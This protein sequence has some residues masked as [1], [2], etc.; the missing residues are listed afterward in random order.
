M[1]L[2]VQGAYNLLSGIGLSR[3]IT[4]RCLVETKPPSTEGNIKRMQ[5]VRTMEYYSAIRKDE[6]FVCFYCTMNYL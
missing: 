4:N 2:G 1:L 6:M 3:H 5:Y